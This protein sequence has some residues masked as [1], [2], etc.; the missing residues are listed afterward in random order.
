MRAVGFFDR[1]R[2]RHPEQPDPV[3]PP[4]VEA[5]PQ[6]TVVEIDASSLSRVF[7]APVWLRDLGLLAWF[8]VGVALVLV[9]LVWFL[10]LTSTI[11][12]PVATGAKIGRAHV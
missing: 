3:P 1:F 10:G 6:R 5:P 9:G 7:S 2:H 11:V 8:L 4:H 12:D